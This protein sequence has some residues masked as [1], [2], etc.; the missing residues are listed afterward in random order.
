[1][2]ATHDALAWLMI[3]C[4]T[5]CHL[6]GRRVVIVAAL[7]FVRCF[8]GAISPTISTNQSLGAPSTSTWASTPS[9]AGRTSPTTSST[10]WCVGQRV[11][12]LL[13][14]HG[15]TH[16]F[17]V[18][19]SAFALCLCVCVCACALVCARVCSQV[20]GQLAARR[21]WRAWWLHDAGWCDD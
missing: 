4:E 1:M 15:L 18:G 21:L 3:D 20:P 9:S 10:T 17:G 19:L 13:L 11:D 12:H 5:N 6:V 16:V 14:T 2:R 7:W 8:V